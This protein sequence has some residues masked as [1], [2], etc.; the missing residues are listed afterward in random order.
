MNTLSADLK[1]ATNDI[2][3][4]KR[5]NDSKSDKLRKIKETHKNYGKL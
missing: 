4:L 5:A 3:Q 2:N 1:K